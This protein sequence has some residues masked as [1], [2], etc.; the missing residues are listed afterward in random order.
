MKK[1]FS[2]IKNP[3]AFCSALIE[4]SNEVIVLTDENFNITYR[5]P[6]AERITGWTTKE[7][8]QVVAL[9]QT[10]PDDTEN[11]KL[12]MSE[13]S[14]NPGKQLPLSFRTKHKAGHYIHLEGTITNLL[15]DENVKGIVTNLRDVTD[16]K[17]FEEKENLF[18]L[19]INSSSDAIISENLDG[20]ITSWNK[21]AEN[22]FG[23]SAT[24]IIGKHISILFPSHL[25]KEESEIISM[26][27]RGEVI[28]HY[29]TERLKKDGTVIRVSLTISPIKDSEGVIVGAFKIS[30]RLEEWK[31]LEE[32]GKR[33]SKEISDYKYA[34]DESSIVAITNQK[35]IIQHVNDNF[36]RISKY[37][38]EELIGQDHRIINSGY[39]PEEFIRV[40]WTTIANGKIWKGELKNKA[41]DGTFYWVDT[42]IVPFLNE[43]GKPYQ[44]IA[45]RADITGRK[46]AEE[47][48][49]KS[50][51]E[52]LDYKYAL[53]ESS[54]VAITNQKGII[55]YVN[56][57]FCKISKYN[58]EELIGQDHSIIN[59]GYHSKE[60]IRTLWTTIAN[61][62]I[63]KGE[64]KNKAKDGTFYWVDTTIVPFLNEKE[65]PF[66]YIAIRS[67]ITARKN[68]EENLQKSL[69][70]T[71]DYK[72]ALDE[73]SIVAITNQKGIIQYANDNF[74]KISQY[75]REELIG[76]D[77]RIINSKHHSEEFIRTLWTTI[78]N[79]KIWNGELKNKAKDGTFY[80]VD[81]SIVPFLNEKGKPYQY[82]AIRADITAR[83]NAEENLKKSLKETLDY[84]YALNES[85]IVAITNQKGIIQYA[86]D[87]FCKISQYSREELIGQDHSMINSGYHPEEFIRELWITIA[88]GKIWKGEI[89]NKAKD[90]TFYWVNTTIVPFL[91]EKGKPYQYVAIR[92]DI[93]K[94]KKTEDELIKI[95]RLYA[96]LSAINQS[97]VHTKD[98]KT[99]LEKAGSIAMEIGKFKSAR[100]GMLD[101]EDKLILINPQE[102]GFADAIQ[103]RVGVDYKSAPLSH[104]PMGKVLNTG[105]HFISN[106]AQNDL[107]LI[108]WK[109]E[110]VDNKIK[111]CASFPIK[112]FNKVVGVFS[113]L[114]DEK[115]F[116]DELEVALLHEAAGDI[117]FALEVFEKEEERELVKQ[118]LEN[119]QSNLQAIIENTDARIYSLDRN[120]RYIAFNHLLQE[121]LQE[122]YNTQVKVGDDVFD[123][124]K[125]SD[126]KEIEN[127]HTI[128]RQAL[129]GETV[130]FEKEF[131][132]NNLSS[133]TSFSI[134][135][136]LKNKNVIGLSCF[137]YDISKQ[138]EEERQKE[139]ITSDLIDRNIDLEHFSYI[140][141]HNL[142]APVA[143]ILGIADLIKNDH[144]KKDEINEI[145]L[146]L[147]KAVD[148]LDIV[149]R[150]LNQILQVSHEVNEKKETVV[151]NEIVNSIKDS[152]QNLIVKEQVNI[153]TDF[154]AVESMVTIKTYMHSIFYNLIS[155]GIKYSK[156]E[157]P[158]TMKIT[159]E[160][161]DD[162]VI[163][164]FKDYGMGIDLDRFGDHVFR[165]YKRFHL[166]VEGKGVGLFMV[167]T[168]VKTLG[169][170]ITIESKVNEGTEFQLEFESV[171]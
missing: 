120:L 93:T 119:S 52:T 60:F 75:S 47:N 98:K 29:E 159:S 125:R 81:T 55:Q 151:F 37:S 105:T 31:K 150:D 2:K 152:I 129:N 9:E 58:R 170:K 112:K 18:P 79:G 16:W 114:S 123:F 67:D 101:E 111:S 61:G 49:K 145:L 100:I 86:N 32:H 169:G 69:K 147:F 127:W 108:S 134:H 56:S 42:T 156:P 59:S 87:N 3:E 83:K 141:S 116:F 109:Q 1:P 66:Q 25:L 82:I 13:V 12:V 36:C 131:K 153:I 118:R 68:A 51:K 71:T 90:G 38:S 45:I 35:G 91:N 106:N 34:L 80:W 77:H 136:I 70:E 148:Q 30:K 126:P 78:A 144:I 27:K 167:K 5:S 74:C 44:Y 43:K 63:W 85:S 7:R 104:T 73:S 103:K 6:S 15:H 133:F 57:N 4:N 164:K 160:K 62:K 157:M 21:A 158:P 137:V 39:H 124:L 97:I 139:K 40:L 28:E 84:K 33:S 46:N 24:E 92:V 121:S 11:L 165:L 142:R 88:N 128:Y 171:E 146:H 10:H 166:D 14:A 102:D 95:N 23:Y 64:L 138:K 130:K 50:L 110:I 107:Q 163:L 135:P 65:K 155:N 154:S 168:Q 53:D 89:K 20:I 26:I 161:I 113:F 149:I 117:S 132:Y 122:A 22:D 41:K 48:L 54:I 140:V 143:N 162:K 19:I 94:R 8:A 76:Q 72:Y 17:K 99:L 96:F 115:D